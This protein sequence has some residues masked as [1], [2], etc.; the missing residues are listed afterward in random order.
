MAENK[1][2]PSCGGQMFMAKIIRACVVEV[3]TDPNEPYKILK[4][5]KDKFDIEILK[6]ARCKEDVKEEDLIAAVQCKECGKMIGPMDINEEGIC[7][8]CAAIKQRA[9]IANASREDLIKMLLDAEKKVNPVAAKME[10]QIEKADDAIQPTTVIPTGTLAESIVEEISKNESED[11]VESEEK[12]PKRRARKKKEDDTTS[13]VE[14]TVVTEESSDEENTEEVTETVTEAVKDIA[15]QQEAPFPD[16]AMNPPVEVS[17]EPSMEEPVVETIATD[18][19]PIGADF[20]MFD[21]NE[22]AF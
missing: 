1:V 16:I 14:D 12:K 21:D 3:T 18:E 11:S 19:Q 4:E 17:I 10:K 13:A 22:E 2:C 20:R 6:C 8:V 5:S 15:N 7:N 9:D